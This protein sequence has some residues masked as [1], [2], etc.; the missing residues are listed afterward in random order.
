MSRKLDTLRA[1]FD[2]I[3]TAVEQIH[4]RATSEAR[5]LTDSEDTDVST[6]LA[7]AD[8]LKPLIEKEVADASKLNDVAAIFARANGTTNTPVATET[9]DKKLAMVNFIRSYAKGEANAL[10]H[11]RALDVVNS[12]TSSGSIPYTIQGGIIDFTQAPRK[13]IDSLQHFPVPNGSSFKRRVL[14]GDSTAIAAQGSESAEIASGNPTLAYVDVTPAT[15]AGGVR[16]TLQ[17]LND[18]TPGAAALWLEHAFKQYAKKTN[19]VVAAALKAAATTTGTLNNSGATA[20]TITD[21]LYK[22]AD[23]VYSACGQEADTIWVSLDV[24][25]W[26]ASRV[27]S[28]GSLIF[29]Q[30]QAS[31]RNGTVDR[32]GA[33]N[34]GLSIGGLNI[35]SE[36]HFASSTFIVGC[37]QYGEVYESM[38]PTLEAWVVPTLEK[39]IAIAGELATYFRSEGFVRLVDNDGNSAATPN[40]G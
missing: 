35:V 16:L 18:T 11:L 25:T 33:L 17:A 34:S 39:E 14:T 2:Q 30:L 4:N 28:Q 3:K 12:A 15:Y 23:T 8:E 10:E 37:S 36:P 24:K 9:P 29:P 26:L 5:D 27:D 20:G 22:A 32:V 38:Y 1:E 40:F 19:T 7:R 6:L 31:N 13:T 21:A